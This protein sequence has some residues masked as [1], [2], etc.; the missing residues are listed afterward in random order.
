MFSGGFK[1]NI[2]ILPPNIQ[3]PRV[4]RSLDREFNL[5]ERQAKTKQTD[6]DS[7]VL[8]YLSN[9]LVTVRMRYLDLSPHPR[10]ACRAWATCWT[11]AS[12]GTSIELAWP[13]RFYHGLCLKGK[14]WSCGHP[15][16]GEPY[17][18]EQTRTNMSRSADRVETH[19]LTD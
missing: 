2:W 19:R 14:P 15:L 17:L 10:P 18:T 11:G 1:R 4:Y 12:S 8:L 5:V 3:R 7:K 6:T 13:R 9:H 16:R